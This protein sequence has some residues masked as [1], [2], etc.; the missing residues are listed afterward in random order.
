MSLNSLGYNIR[1][2][3]NGFKGTGKTTLI[4]TLFGNSLSQDLTVHLK[5]DFYSDKK[6]KQNIVESDG[7][8]EAVTSWAHG[9]VIMVS[10]SSLISFMYAEDFII[11]AKEI[12]LKNAP[13]VLVVNNKDELNR[14]VSLTDCI[15]LA[16]KYDCKMYELSAQNDV[17]LVKELFKDICIEIVSKTRRRSKTVKTCPVKKA[18]SIL[19]KMLTF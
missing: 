14:K 18:P 9:V 1:L 7:R 2:T 16:N 17:K 11:R 13:I 19:R 4:Q 3:V 5:E 12:T 6:V 15:K 10:T 8:N